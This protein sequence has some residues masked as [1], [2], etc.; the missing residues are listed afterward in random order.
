MSTD[1]SKGSPNLEALQFLQDNISPADIEKMKEIAESVIKPINVSKTVIAA[2]GT[3]GVAVT[4]IPEGALIVDVMVIS[5]ATSAS[6]TV[7]LTNGTDAVATAITMAVAGA[8]ARL[9]AGVDST[10]LV[11]SEDGLTLTTNGATDF[12]IV[13]IFYVEA[14]AI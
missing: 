10:K 6:G 8:V 14:S 1:T 5:T 3:G 13:Y 2:D 4:D 7:A 11:V 9:A 12:G